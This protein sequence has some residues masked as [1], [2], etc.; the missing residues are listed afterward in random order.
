M[1]V[2]HFCPPL[3]DLSLNA[4]GLLQYIHALIRHAINVEDLQPPDLDSPVILSLVSA[5]STRTLTTL[6]IFVIN[7]SGLEGLIYI[8]DMKNLQSLVVLGENFGI[9]S[10]V[11]PWTLPSL[12]SLSLRWW[13]IPDQQVNNIQFLTGSIFPSLRMLSLMTAIIPSPGLDPAF[14][15]WCA[16]S[17][18]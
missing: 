5:L 15:P 9:E 14:A 13:P 12:I 10:G 16:A 8:N 6:H 3:G 7:K 2:L 1:K 11:P 4:P 17:L 18:Q